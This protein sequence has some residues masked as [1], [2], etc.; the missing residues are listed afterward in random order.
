MK[1]F[2]H[3]AGFAVLAL[4]LASC[5]TANQQAKQLEEKGQP[6]LAYENY[7]R[8]LLHNPG[9]A[10]AIAGMTRTAPGAV[11]YWQG[12][13]KTFGDS[14]ALE[15]A[16]V[17]HR[18]VLRIKPDEQ[19]SIDWLREHKMDVPEGPADAKIL[20]GIT[21]KQPPT[22]VTIN[23]GADPNA[24]VGVMHSATTSPAPAATQAPIA[25]ATPAPTPKP[26]PMVVAIATPAPTPA[27]T[28]VPTPKPTPAPTPVVIVVAT[29]APTPSPTPKPT[30]VVVAVATPAPTPAPAKEPD[31][32]VR[33]EVKVTR[34]VTIESDVAQG[35]TTLE[36]QRQKPQ[37]RYEKNASMDSMILTVRISNDDK[38]FPKFTPLM[39]GL[40]VRVKDTDGNPLNADLEFYYHDKKVGEKVCALGIDSVVSL[41]GSSG[42]TWEIV[43]VG[44]Y[45]KTE[46][47]TLGLRKRK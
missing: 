21:Q 17:C 14:G 47:V 13:A 31:A 2:T 41:R 40:S 15:E 3:A 20:A 37:V 7:R 23:S 19:A 29:P 43:I 44:I 6:Q 12:Q 24:T 33:T 11:T 16:A 42:T 26:T 1:R 32:T 5:S 38:R 10:T 36:L 8:A 30:P 45:N 22:K 28:P 4:L 39:E 18:T 46:T 35:P 25:L 9:D 34:E 27:P